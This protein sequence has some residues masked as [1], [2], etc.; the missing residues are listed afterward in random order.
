MRLAKAKY[1][2]SGVEKTYVSAVEKLILEQIIGQDFTEEW[3]GFRDKEL[4][5]MTIHDMLEPNIPGLRKV[6]EAHFAPRKKFMDMSDVVDVLT[7]QT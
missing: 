3:Q 4:W 6:Y 1:L 5:T 2:D 7:R